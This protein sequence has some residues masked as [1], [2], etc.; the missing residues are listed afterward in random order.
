MQRAMRCV[1]ALLASSAAAAGAPGA[2]FHVSPSGSDD[3]PGTQTRPFRTLEAARDAVRKLKRPLPAGGVTVWLRG[4][5]HRLTKTFE[6][7]SRDSGAEGSPIVY[8]AVVGEVVRIT[9]RREIPADAF[10]PAADEAVL[11]KLDPAVRG[12]VLAADL[13]AMGIT[14]YGRM[15]SRGFGRAVQ[16]AA[17]ELIFDDRLMQ[18]ARWPNEGRTKYAKVIDA[19]SVPRGGDGADRG[20]SFEY[21]GDRPA[22]WADAPDAFIFAYWTYHWADDLIRVRSIDAKTR[23]ITLAQPHRYGMNP[24]RGSAHAREQVYC[25]LNI[26]AELDA[27]GEYYVDRAAGVLYFRPPSPIGAARVVVTMLEGPLVAMAGASHVTWRGVVFE[28]TRGCGVS[29][30]GGSHNRIAGCTLRNIGTAAVCIGEGADGR[31][32]GN[33]IGK[34]YADTAW[35]RNGG[36]DNG[37]VSCDIHHTGAAGVILGGGDR[38]TLIP[39]GNFVVNCDIHHAGRLHKQYH[40]PVVVD[41]V[42]NRIARCRLHHS[43]HCAVWFYGNDHVIELNEIDH[44]ALDSDDA[45]PIES[46]RDPSMQGLIVRN[47]FFHHNGGRPWTSDIFLDDGISGEIITGNV[48]YKPGPRGAL[49]IHAGLFHRF[50][51]NIVIEGPA[52]VMQGMWNQPRWAQWLKTPLLRKRMLEA[53]DCSKPP[54]STRYP[55]L[56]RILAAEYDRRTNVAAG[57][58]LVRCKRVESGGV[59]LRDN[60]VTGDDPGF[61]DAAKM[62]FALKDDSVVY[63]KLPG[64]RKIPFGEIGLHE[65]E[66]RK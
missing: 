10:R 29:M 50:E 27:P 2:S 19:G 42:G 63:R 36:T 51:G 56:K 64:F 45:A 7:T 37:V 1:V 34:M 38:K 20:G 35:D 49:F 17:M 59:S 40:P 5:V 4:G 57:N 44:C 47:N 25:A 23:R 43:P 39:G 65:D 16:P 52:A 46:G 24:A 41:G 6:L 8:R 33:V 26:L 14:D 3:S 18:L 54:F 62:N 11:Q 53:V 28:A 60:F 9:G 55:N 21:V 61:V 12:K 32:I 30:V 13:K 58:V 66:Y 48:F 31:R 22:R 15:V